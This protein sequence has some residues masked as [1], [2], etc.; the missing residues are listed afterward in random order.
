MIKVREQVWS[1]EQ[2]A[3]IM[4][5]M[6]G[7]SFLS[8]PGGKKHVIYQ[9]EHS[10]KQS[11]YLLWKAEILGMTHYTRDRYD[12]RTDKTYHSVCAYSAASP[13]FNELRAR[14]YKDG[15]KKLN[16]DILHSMGPLSLS[17]WFWDD[18][19]TNYVGRVCKLHTEKYTLL[20]NQKI[21]QWFIERWGLHPTIYEKMSN[22][23]MKYIL[24]FN[25]SDSYQLLSII[26]PFCPTPDL[27]YKCVTKPYGKR[28]PQWYKD[29]M[30]VQENA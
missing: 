13:T 2:E 14:T 15:Y 27:A 7:D 29:L 16:T 20:E 22:G 6:M 3:I 9:M 1:H 8:N 30:E 17:I 11:A 18:G 26:R 21:Q 23:N 10:D 12:V 24:A 28:M 25:V 4:G 5:G 19:H